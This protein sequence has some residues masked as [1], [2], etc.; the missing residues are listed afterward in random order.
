[1]NVLLVSPKTRDTFWSFRHALPFIGKKAAY[2]PLG[3]LTV[4]GFLPREWNLK[5]VDLD[6]CRL[7]DDKILWADYVLVGAMIVHSDSVQ[8]IAARCRDLHRP[9]IAGGPLFSTNRDRFPQI[10]H[11]AV[12]E[13]EEYMDVLIRDMEEGRV[14]ALYEPDGYPKLDDSPIPLW[15]LIDIGDYANMSIQFSRGCPFDCEFCDITFLNGRVPRTKTPEQVIAEL[16]SLCEA[17]WKGSVFVV[18]DNFLGHK[19]KVKELLRVMIEWRKRKSPKVEFLTEASLNLAE[20][21]ELLELAVEAGFRT[22]F[23]GI[24]T[25]DVDSLVAC[26]KKQ[27]TKRDLLD[28]VRAIQKAGLEV[29]GGFIIGFDSDK[30]DIFERQFRFIQEAGVV[31]AMVGLL[32]A[33]PGTKLHKRLASEGRL[34]ST[35]TGNHTEADL[36]FVTTLGRE[37]LISGYREL[38]KRLYEPRAYYD[39]AKTLLRNWRPRGAYAF[40]GRRDIRALFHGLWRLGVRDAGRRHF[41]AFLGHTLV[42]HPRAFTAAM[43][44]AV[45][46]HHLRMVAKSI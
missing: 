32:N 9:L 42:H 12:G 19:R 8:E 7:G 27:N 11:F 41:W 36:N 21:T 15:K 6:V 16:D 14:G 29:M 17:G 46:G 38:M 37:K 45:C 23:L 10:P 1:M 22:V 2:P 25:P 13:V 5:L 34:L 28:S 3:L 4:A 33:I 26:N 24:E 35:S 40:Q 30:P 31:T 18:D 43:T 39:R 20:E 44:F